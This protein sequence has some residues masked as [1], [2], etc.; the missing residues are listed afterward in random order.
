MPIFLPHEFP[1][2]KVIVVILPQQQ[3]TQIHAWLEEKDLKGWLKKMAPR[4][5]AKA[6]KAYK[7]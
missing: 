5:V 7:K 4:K 3:H 1:M 2:K 6:Y